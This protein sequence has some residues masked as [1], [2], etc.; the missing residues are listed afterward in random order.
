[1]PEKDEAPPPRRLSAGWWVAMTLSLVLIL[2]GAAIGFLGPRL[3]PPHPSTP[4]AG[5]A[6]RPGAAK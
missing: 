6:T 5:L 4:P 1:M 3:F 2:A